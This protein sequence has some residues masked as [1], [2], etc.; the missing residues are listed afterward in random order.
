MPSQQAIDRFTLAFHRRAVERLR[1]QAALRTQA[2]QVL[3]RWEA[4][5]AS[6]SGRAYRDQWRRLLTGEPEVL[7]REICA[8][9]DRAA[10]L[11]SMSPLGFVLSPEERL[12]LRREAMA[13]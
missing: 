4:Q 5:G 12:A 6:V 10:T 3:D 7:E 8:A 9:T 1:A 13:E 11:R 2:L